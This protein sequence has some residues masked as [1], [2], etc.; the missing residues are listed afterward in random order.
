M[1]SNQLHV[2]VDKSCYMHFSPN[3][4][5]MTCSRSSNL[6]LYLCG[7]MLKKVDKV[8]F[9]GVVIDEKLSWEAHIDH[10]EVK[11]NSSIVMIKGIKR[12]IPKSEYLKIYNALFMPHLSYCISC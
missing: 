10:L 6:N 12:F 4:E 11:L 8:K 9:L 5:K 2:N 3:S 1:L 7:K